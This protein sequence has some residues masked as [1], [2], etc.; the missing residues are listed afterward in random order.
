VQSDGIF[1]SRGATTFG[2]GTGVAGSATNY[3]AYCFAP[4]AGYSAFSSYTGNLS[5]DGPFVYLG[6]RPRYLLIKASAGTASSW[7]V[8]D[9]TRMPNNPANLYILADSAGAEGPFTYLDINANGFKIR[10]TNSGVNTSTATY[11]YAAFAENPFK[12]ANAR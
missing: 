2:V 12:Y 9:T 11:I 10:T 5:A 6:F 7:L 8:I 3:V 1:T 4:V